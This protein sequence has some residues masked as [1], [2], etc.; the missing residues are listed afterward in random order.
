MQ[1]PST[2]VERLHHRNS[3]FVLENSNYSV[4]QIDRVMTSI[5]SLFETIEKFCLVVKLVTTPVVLRIRAVL[6][7]C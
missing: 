7:M 4:C 3:P 6:S 2:L 1:S 5:I